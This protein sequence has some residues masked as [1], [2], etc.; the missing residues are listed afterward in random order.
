M[1]RIDLHSFFNLSL[2]S[3]SAYNYYFPVK[4]FGSFAQ[5]AFSHVYKMIFMYESHALTWTKN[6]LLIV[7]C[8]ERFPRWFKLEKNSFFA[9]IAISIWNLWIFLCLCVCSSQKSFEQ[10]VTVCFFLASQNILYS[11]SS[12]RIWCEAHLRLNENY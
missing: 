10:M 5:Y 3:V 8:L 1:N 12:R 4:R 9:W 2:S 11:K 6:L 7:I